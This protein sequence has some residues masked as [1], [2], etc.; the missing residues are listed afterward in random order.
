MFVRKISFFLKDR[1]SRSIILPTLLLIF[2]V[3]L[4]TETAQGSGQLLCDPG[5]EDSTANGTFPDSGCWKPSSAGGGAYAVVTTTAA[6]SGNN[7]LWIY[8]GNES[9]AYWSR[10][11]QQ[12]SAAPGQTYSG[13]AWICTPSGEDWVG[14]SL[15]SVRIE[16]LNDTGSILAAKSSSGVTT[17]NSGW[18]QYSL[19]SDPALTGTAY[20]RF[21]CNIEKPSGVSGISVANFDDTFFELS[22]DNQPPN[23]PSNP[24]PSDGSTGV[25]PRP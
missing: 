6:R 18:A 21:I 8:T 20:V 11:Y 23:T 24:S 5:F 16:F 14:G 17:T 1:H 9:W 4:F 15:A 7:G 12:F 3:T 10:P 2:F 19:T 22:V 25:L 13:S